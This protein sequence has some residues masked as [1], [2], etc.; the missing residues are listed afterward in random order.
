MNIV[1][2][3]YTQPDME[4]I[5]ALYSS[6]GWTNYSDNP[7]M[8]KAAVDNS[9]KVLAAFDGEKLVGII[10]VVGDGHSIIYIQDKIVLQEYQR[11]GLGKRLMLEIEALYSH[12]Y[13]KVLLTDDQPHSIG[14]YEGCGFTLSSEYHCVAFMKITS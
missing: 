10:R 2:K 6:V 14:F 1:I 12:V 13:Q 11:Q 9:L 4:Q 8:L 3:E 5:L 7:S